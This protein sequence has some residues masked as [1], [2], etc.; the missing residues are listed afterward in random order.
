MG[1]RHSVT[2]ARRRGLCRKLFDCFYCVSVWVAV[3]LAIFTGETWLE[4]VL[5]WPSLSAAAILLERVTDR[6]AK[7]PLAPFTEDRAGEKENVML[8]QKEGTNAHGDSRPP[9]GPIE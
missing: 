9:G 4:R 7:F 5:L 8:R 6:G 1:C 3:P 2:S